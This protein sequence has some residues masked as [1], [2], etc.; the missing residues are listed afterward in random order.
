MLKKSIKISS[1]L[2]LSMVVFQACGDASSSPKDKD[3]SLTP[4]EN[5]PLSNPSAGTMMVSKITGNI[6]IETQINVFCKNGGYYSTRSQNDTFTLIIPTNVECHI[7]TKH[8]QANTTTP[9]YTALALK[10]SDGTTSSGFKITDATI[11]LQDINLA[12]TPQEIEDN[13]ANSM[14]DTP[15]TVS[16][17]QGDIVNVTATDDI[18][19]SDNNGIINLFEDDD[20]DGIIN[21]IDSDDENDDILD[22]DGDGINDDKDVDIDNDGNPDRLDTDG[23]PQGPIA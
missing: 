12:L 8:Q 7:V 4:T 5:F 13:D 9:L 15:L 17:K 10:S 1:L 21:Y 16:L 6:P 3:E 20:S 23:T 19:D 22:T 11:E 14:I 18:M 2:V